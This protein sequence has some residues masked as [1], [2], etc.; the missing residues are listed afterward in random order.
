M[1]WV[2]SV[3]VKGEKMH[4]LKSGVVVPYES[5]VPRRRLMLGVSTG[6]CREGSCLCGI[7]GLQ[8][9]SR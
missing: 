5:T 9:Q 4:H 1:T 3:E 7:D 8:T 2:A 6:G